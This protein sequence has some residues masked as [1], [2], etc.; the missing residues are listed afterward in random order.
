LKDYNIKENL[1][2]EEIL[3]YLRK[4]RADDPQLSVEEVLANHE[5]KLKEWEDRNLIYPVPVENRFR[6]L[7]SGESISDRNAFQKVLKLIES[8]QYKAVLVVDISRLGRPDTMEIG[9]ISKIFRFTNTLVI[10]PDRIFNVSDEFE[11]RMF[12]EELKQGNFYLEYTK[13]RLGDGRDLSAKSGNFICSKPPYGYDKTT[14]TDGKKKCPTLAINEEQA[15][16]VCM[17]F[18]AY[19][20]ENIGTQNIANRLNDMGIKSPRGKLWTPDSI[21]TILENPVYTGMIR[22][23]ERKAIVIVDNGNFRKTRPKAPEEERIFSKGKHEAI[24]SDEL[25]YAAQEKR[26]RTHRT[27]DNKELR[28]PLASILYCE[29][30]RAMTYRHST[31][32]NLIYKEPRLVCNGQKYCGSGSC[33]VSEMLDFVVEALKRRISEFEIEAQRGDDGSDKLHEKLAKSLEKKLLDIDAKELSLWESQVD[34]DMAKRMPPHVFQAI[35]DKLAK[36]REETETALK[37]AREAIS[38]P[39]NYEKTRVTLQKALNAMLDDKVS[40]AEKNHLLKACI[41]KIEYQRDAP[42]R[43]V[44]TGNHAAWTT[45]PIH[46]DVKFKV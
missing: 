46:L 41:S 32:G 3:I 15:N 1:K 10:T 40:V 28:N 45:P 7:V 9:L 22:W 8:P 34:P 29:C 36:E 20:N 18:D 14:I 21:R 37:K 16:I 2:P 42:E 31:R 30:G 5:M 13:K 27:C 26:G 11:R 19:V 17:I 33:T 25:F 38:A 35:T 6:D 44:G 39:I 43:K 12:E 24:I 23:K 4:S